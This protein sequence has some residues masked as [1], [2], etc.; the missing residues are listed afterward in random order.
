[1]T[2]FAS[3]IPSLIGLGTKVGTSI[4]GL[5]KPP[6]QNTAREI[7]KTAGTQYGAA[8]G[9]A[10]TGHGASRSLA[11]REGLR[12]GTAGVAQTSRAIGQAAAADQSAN[13]QRELDR[14]GRIAD[15]GSDLAKGLGDMATI[16]IKAKQ[17]EAPAG[18]PA[19]EEPLTPD[20]QDFYETPGTGVADSPLPEDDSAGL[21][22]IEQ[23]LLDQEAVEQENLINDAQQ[24][25]DQLQQQREELMPGGPKAAFQPDPV[26]TAIQGRPAAMAPQ[27]E[28][29]LADRLHMKE[30]M[31]SE[32]ERLGVPLETII[33]RTNRRLQLRPGQSTGNPF[34]IDPMGEE[35]V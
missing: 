15:F 33:A 24:G 31:L 10:Q 16:G 28:Q 12:R 13:I 30:L 6:K 8:V 23:Q 20:E 2:A 25:L 14:R 29:Q 21:G 22:D 18:A 35:G 19:A 7:A 3:L 9:A 27:I 34:G 1:M 11:L 32:A 17:G 26:T 4:P 5:R